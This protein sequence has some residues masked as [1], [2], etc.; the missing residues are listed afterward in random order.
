MAYKLEHGGDD[1]WIEDEG[2]QPHP[3]L[4]A[5][6]GQDVNIENPIEK[7]SW[8]NVF[9]LCAMDRTRPSGL[10][11][12]IFDAETAGSELWSEAHTAATSNPVTVTG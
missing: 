8:P 11:F 10:V 2:N 7:Y 5:R 12:R 4:T 9:R 3:T 1:I 6:A